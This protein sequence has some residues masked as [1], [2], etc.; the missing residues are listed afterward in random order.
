MRI[1]TIKMDIII[2]AILFLSCAK[3]NG[4]KEVFISKVTLF[5]SLDYANTASSYEWPST[6]GYFKGL[7]NLGQEKKGQIPY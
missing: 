1:I 7:I 5:Q 3:Y 6:V 2:L 4:K